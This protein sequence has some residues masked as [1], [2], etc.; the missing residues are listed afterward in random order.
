LS[1]ES[2]LGDLVLE[3]PRARKILFDIFWTSAGWR[4]SRT[5]DPD[6]LAYARTA[7]Y[8]FESRDGTHDDWVSRARAAADRVTLEE[9]ASAFVGSLGSRRL[10]ARSALGSL[11]TARHLAPHTFR[12]WSVSCGECGVYPSNRPENLDVLSFERH[13]WGGVRHGDPVYAWFD[14]DLF[15]RSERPREDPRDVDTLNRVL[16]A[17]REAKPD[18]RPSDLE[19]AIAPLLSSS[20]DE[21][22]TLLGILAMCNILGAPEHPG[23][24]ARWVPYVE[25]Q[26]PPKPSK[27]DWLYPM[28]WWRGSMGVNEAAARSVFGARIR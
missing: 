13:K 21:R 12:P 18:A 24:L 2:D 17:A 11:A 8:M 22:R 15:A 20:K 19:R 16:D 26:P 5:T 1:E 6:D 4:T 23:L 27:N 25:R 3:D 28:F 10:A 7:G 9:V 14:L